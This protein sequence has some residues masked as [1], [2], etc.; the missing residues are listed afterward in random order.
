[1]WDESRYVVNAFELL[2]HKNF[3]VTTY[4][5]SPD[6]WATKPPLMIWILAGF[7]KVFG[8]N[9]LAFRLPSALAATITSVAVFNFVKKHTD[10]L[11]AAFF[12]GMALITSIG[13]IGAHV[14]RTA[15]T[16]ALMVMFLTLFVFSF[17]D[18]LVPTN[19]SEKNQQP[20][21]YKKLYCATAYLALAFLTKSAS[22]L[23]FLPG[24]FLLIILFRRYDLLRTA[25][26]YIA[27]LISLLPCT[28]YFLIRE[29]MNPGYLSAVWNLDFAD[30]YFQFHGEHR[31]PFSFYFSLL[32]QEQFVPWFFLLPFSIIV[33]IKS[34]NKSVKNLMLASFVIG[35]SFLFIVSLSQCKIKYYDAGFYPFGAI[36][37]GLAISA[38]CTAL[39]RNV[40]NKLIRAL[41]YVAVFAGIYYYPFRKV[42]SYANIR[43][44]EAFTYQLKY[45]P[46]MD[47]IYATG[48]NEPIKFFETDY[49]AHLLFYSD[50]YK[51]KGKKIEIIN[52]LSDVKDGEL[53]ATCSPKLKNQINTSYLVKVVAEDENCSCYKILCTR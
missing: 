31:G 40:G 27:T 44:A 30:R 7:M 15:D 23:M 42:L 49:H 6:L 17:Y 37:V 53:I 24:S 28:L 13:F 35:F 21:S 8:Y 41:V 18:F 47:S 33:F 51:L 3:I 48:F 14:A 9:E 2:Q 4:D 52:S 19:I 11:A 5:G 36:L 43:P 16:D 45:G 29:R 46:F 26:L 39:I 20:Q 38:L 50:V 25:H 1:M 10:D 34:K 22:G 32:L 12:S